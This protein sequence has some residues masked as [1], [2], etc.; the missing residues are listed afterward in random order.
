MRL[1]REWLLLLGSLLVMAALY[2][3]YM[4]HSAY[5][6]EIIFVA[7]GTSLAVYSL[8]IP[9]AKPPMVGEGLVVQLLSKVMSRE[10][11]AQFLPLAGFLLILA[12]SGW[13]L[14]VRG[15]TDLRME[16]FIVTLFG[17]SLVLYYSGP[18]QYTVQKDF[19]VL[20]L[21][22]LTI[23]F[24]VIWKLYT[25]LTGES[26]A[27]ITAYSEYYFITMPVVF[28]V[29]LLGVHADYELDLS[30]GG[31]S[32]II[33]YEYHGEMAYVGIGT[34]CSGLYSAGLFFSAFL[35]FVLVRYKRIDKYT[36]VALGLGFVVTWASNI[37]RMAITILVGHTWGHP[38]L[39]FV[40]SYIGIIIFVAFVTVFWYFIVRW[41]DVKERDKVAG[42]APQQEVAAQQT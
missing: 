7:V 30:G 40:H 10:K 25:I 13:K 24:A 1:Q 32:N 29:K 2:N 33:A 38:A 5:L 15:E 36:L 16:D 39:V 22:F 12:W 35:A 26:Y 11:C 23:V 8:M 21:M 9:S 27:R 34:G 28:L 31:L 3:H 14:F 17:L 37:V 4:G 19:I 18:S 41:L 42:Q 20:Y 6:V